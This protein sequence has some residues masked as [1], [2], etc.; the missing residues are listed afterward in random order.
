MGEDV[1]PV[2]ETTVSFNRQ[3][4]RIQWEP[5]AIFLFQVN[6]SRG[7]GEENCRSTR[8]IKSI[9]KVNNRRSKGAS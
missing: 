2:S 5:F 6:V 3:H 4:R 1:V 7:G 8:K 9:D